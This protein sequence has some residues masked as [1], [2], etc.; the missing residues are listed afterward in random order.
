MTTSGAPG[1]W[2]A[3]ARLDA[4]TSAPPDLLRW[5][6]WS[7]PERFE[8]M[9]RW[10]IYTVFALPPFFALTI[11]T[12][13]TEWPSGGWVLAWVILTVVQAVLGA[14]V[15][16]AAMRVYSNQAPWPRARML[17]LAAAVVAVT[18]VAVVG[19][20]GPGPILGLAL[21]IPL[22]GAVMAISPLPRRLPTLGLLAVGAGVLASSVQLLVGRPVTSVIPT[23]IMAVLG[24]T[25]AALSCRLSVWMMA[26]VWQLDEARAVAGRLA[27]AEER[28]RFSR[29]LHDV[30]GRTLSTVAVK[31][32]LASALAERGDPQGAEQ[33]LQVRQ[34]AH[35]ALREVRGLVQGY[36][37]ADLDTE[38]A[39]AREL[40]RSAGVEVRVAGQGLTLPDE[41]AESVAWVV[42][43]AVTNIVRHAVAQRCEIDVRVLDDVCRVR[44]SNDGVSG[45]ADPSTG[46]NGLRG[47]RERLGARGG[48]LRVTAEESTFVVEA[49]VPMTEGER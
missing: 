17:L 49:T 43:E 28:L 20:P 29:D 41:V 14:R 2:W 48:T 22:A 26:V 3:R 47:L 32:E 15:F 37:S 21:L 8:V 1:A 35:D 31:S 44:I 9:T 13:A 45:V 23:M 39:G 7:N 33:M 24:V 10:S 19:Y 16:V 25:G 11:V 30:F 42:R 27:V 36:R 38:I 34:I 12:G 40:L 4:V 6:E 5:K 46:G 18:V